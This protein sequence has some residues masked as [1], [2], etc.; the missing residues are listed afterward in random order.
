M[1]GLDYAVIVLMIISIGVGVLRGAVREI[2][3]IAGWVLAFIL[4]R[5][6]AP[7][8]AQHFAEWASDPSLRL[9]AAWVAVFLTVLLFVALIT[10]LVTTLVRQLGL[11]GLDR[12][13]GALIGVARGFVVLFALMLAAGFTTLPQA[14]I[15]REAA[16]T[17]WLEMAALHAR[18]VLPEAI[19][20]KIQYRVR[21]NTS[22]AN[23]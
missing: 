11:G 23:S 19:G 7:D 12:T 4:S 22:A 17:P 21:S 3:N 10:S 8:V 13:I 9:V 20:S 18:A 16:S 1:N 5:M 15:W 6:F 2:M 14:P